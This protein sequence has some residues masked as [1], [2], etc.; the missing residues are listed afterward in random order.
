MFHN[1]LLTLQPHGHFFING[2]YYDAKMDNQPVVALP[3]D[4][5]YVTGSI[6]K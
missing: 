6:G 5:P 2:L 3:E 1:C 4:I